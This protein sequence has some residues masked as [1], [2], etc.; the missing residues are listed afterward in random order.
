MRTLLMFRAR[1]SLALLAAVM[2]SACAVAP[3]LQVPMAGL[4]GAQAAGASAGKANLAVF[5]GLD[6][7]NGNMEG[8]LKLVHEGLAKTGSTPA[9]SIYL[10][11]D[12][13]LKSD[14]FRTKVTK[15]QAWRQSFQSIGEMNTGNA[16]D[17]RD[18][19]S[20]TGKQSPAETTHLAVMTHGGGYAGMLWD[21]QGAANSAAPSTGMTLKKAFKTIGKGFQGSRLDSLTFDACMM[22]TIEVGESLKGVTATFNGTEDFSIMASMPWD[23]VSAAAQVTTNRTGEGFSRTVAQLMIDKGRWGK[24]G[25]LQWSALRLNRD[26]DVLVGKVDRLSTALQRALKREPDA[27]RQAA[28]DTRMFAVMGR[29][30][31]HYGDYYQRDLTEFCQTLQRRVQDPIV[32]TAAKDVEA[33]IRQ[34]VIVN[35]RHASENMANGLAIFL[36]HD[37]QGRGDLPKAYRDTAFARHTHWDEFLLELNGATPVAAN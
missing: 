26:W 20:W 19:L 1:A 36:P 21:Y 28:R 37:M 14:G 22:A 16:P 29:F 31:D 9:M 7:Y 5:V 25:A 32:H 8:N 17:L 6:D 35:A 24:D 13:D 23:A 4:P 30:K 34:V 18:F 27:V 3:T 10:S 2:A 12:T 15:G 11:G 33:A